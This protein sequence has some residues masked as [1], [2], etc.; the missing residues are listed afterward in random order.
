MSISESNREWFDRLDKFTLCEIICLHN[1]TSS[2]E[3]LRNRFLNYPSYIQL[4]YSSCKSILDVFG[5]DILKEIQKYQRKNGVDAWHYLYPDN[6]TKIFLSKDMAKKILTLLGEEDK[7]NFLSESD[8]DNTIE[9]HKTIKKNNRDTYERR[10]DSYDS[11][12]S[13]SGIEDKN[14]THEQILNLLKKSN[15]NLWNICINTFLKDFWQIYSTENNCKKKS[16]RPVKKQ[17]DSQE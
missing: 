16:G 1:G 3:W 6:V 14:Y 11:Y 10:K 9:T 8:F 7:P 5:E 4:E 12:K 2:F 15:P 13:K 17:R